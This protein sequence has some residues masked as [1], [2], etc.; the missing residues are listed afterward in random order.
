M[1]G[2]TIKKAT[3]NVNYE[4]AGS[5]SNHLYVGWVSKSSYPNIISVQP[6]DGNGTAGAYLNGGIFS[7]GYKYNWGNYHC[8]AIYGDVSTSNTSFIQST[9]IYYY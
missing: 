6:A 8:I 3:E 1:G 5:F 4:A 2:T 7:F 9:I